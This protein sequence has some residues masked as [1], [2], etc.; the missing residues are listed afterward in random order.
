MAILT[1]PQQIG[2][3]YKVSTF[4][5]PPRPLSIQFLRGGRG[6]RRNLRVQPVLV[7]QK[8]KLHNMHILHPEIAT[9][10]WHS[11]GQPCITA[12]KKCDK[13]NAVGDINQ[14]QQLFKFAFIDLYH[15]CRKKVQHYSLLVWHKCSHGVTFYTARKG[16]H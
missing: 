9:R 15:I 13:T 2:V 5:A 7:P 3:P 6:R 4:S 16:R 10:A 8:E 12:P 11:V 1:Q 14:L